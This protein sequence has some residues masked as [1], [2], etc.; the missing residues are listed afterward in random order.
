MAS[1]VP[2]AY[3]RVASQTYV[4]QH[5]SLMQFK[6]NIAEYGLL[7]FVL[8]INQPGYVP[9]HNRPAFRTYLA[10]YALIIHRVCVHKK[11]EDL[12]NSLLPSIYEGSADIGQGR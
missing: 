5:I 7:L 3:V 9:Q 8:K 2:T 6:W 12:L 11:I 4:L 10:F 1:N